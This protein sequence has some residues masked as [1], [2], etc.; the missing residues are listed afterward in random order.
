MGY[1]WKFGNYQTKDTNQ[2]NEPCIVY[3]TND[4]NTFLAN[5]LD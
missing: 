2:V 5:I 1:Q 3:Y 4:D